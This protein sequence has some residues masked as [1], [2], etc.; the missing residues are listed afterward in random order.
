MASG[1]GTA[2]VG[3][4]TALPNI[5]HSRVDGEHELE[6]V[7]EF[8]RKLGQGSFGIV[9]EVIHKPTGS[10]WACK[11]V[12]KEKVLVHVRAFWR[13]CMHVARTCVGIADFPWHVTFQDF[14]R[15]QCPCKCESSQGM[16]LKSVV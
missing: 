15:E 16:V 4:A 5:P 11:V 13:S 7:Y 8:R 9:R 6:N 12:N 14:V 3:S 10:Q 1:K 2:R